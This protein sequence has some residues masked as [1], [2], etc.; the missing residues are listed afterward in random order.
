MEAMPIPGGMMAIG[1]PEYRLP[2]DVL[3][4]EIDRIVGLGVELRLDSV[5]GRDYSLNDLEA[6][7]FNAV[8][9][10]TG[11]PKSRRLGVPGDALSGVIPATVFL[12]QVN[13][14]EEPRLSGRIVVV[15]GGSTAMD[16]ARSALRSGAENGHRPVPAQLQGDAGPA[17]G[18][19]CGQARRG[20][21]SGSGPP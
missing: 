13:L 21:S 4:A 9:L 8:F 20:S 14:G 1:I 10:A 3:R 15:G 18:G 16:A 2:R 19:R 12:K 17:R 11:A 6:Q 5:M 7:G